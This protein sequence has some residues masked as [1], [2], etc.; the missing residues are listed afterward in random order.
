[1]ERGLIELVYHRTVDS[2]DPSSLWLDAEP[3]LS[4]LCLF[5]SMMFRPARSTQGVVLRIW[6][7]SFLKHPNVLCIIPKA[8]LVFAAAFEHCKLHY[9]SLVIQIP[10]SRS[11]AEN[12]NFTCAPALESG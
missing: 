11:C 12:P 1:M 3:S 9:N 7:P 8:F 10:K 2:S 4:F 6:N 5:C